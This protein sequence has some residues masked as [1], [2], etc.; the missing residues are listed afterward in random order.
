M[1]D[2]Q[3]KS[4]EFGFVCFKTSEE[5]QKALDYFS[6]DKENSVGKK[7]YVVEAKSK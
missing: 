5:A 3:L 7:L 4:R 6:A 1:R 2:D